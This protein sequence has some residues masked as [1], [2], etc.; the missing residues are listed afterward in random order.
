MMDTPHRRRERVAYD[1]PTEAKPR[2]N[3]SHA[4]YAGEEERPKIWSKK[5]ENFI[6]A[7]QGSGIIMV[8]LNFLLT[9]G[10]SRH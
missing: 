2:Q 10:G 6:R 8:A 9:S 1:I 3:A 4:F 5:T 7:G